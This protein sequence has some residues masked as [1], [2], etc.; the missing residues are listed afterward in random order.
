MLLERDQRIDRRRGFFE[1]GMDSLMAVELAERLSER[2]GVTLAPPAVFDHPTIELLTE[3][4]LA[5]VLRV[6]RADPDLALLERVEGL[7]DAEA[8][9]LLRARLSSIEESA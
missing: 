9:A 5:D 8:E 7:T 2:F 3:H 6:P 4:I 1:L